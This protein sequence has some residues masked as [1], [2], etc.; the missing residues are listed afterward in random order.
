MPLML[1]T[2]RLNIPDY[3][4]HA[5]SIDFKGIVYLLT[6]NLFTIDLAGPRD[7]QPFR[8]CFSPFLLLVLVVVVLQQP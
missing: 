4:V 3:L 1:K 7:I 6:T 8:C 2:T 5:V